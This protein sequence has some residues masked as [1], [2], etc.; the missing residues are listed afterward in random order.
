[1]DIGLKMNQMNEVQK[2]TVIYAE[3]EAIRYVCVVLKG[4][5]ELYNE[6]SRIVLGHL[7][8]RSQRRWIEHAC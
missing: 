3:G 2:G 6:G 8:H 4:C 7:P 5:V 1:M